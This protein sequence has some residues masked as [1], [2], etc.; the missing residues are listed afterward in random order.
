MSSK[1]RDGMHLKLLLESF[2]DDD[3]RF[4]LELATLA[5]KIKSEVLV[6]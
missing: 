6:F 4:S 3:T 1:A 5:S 2:M